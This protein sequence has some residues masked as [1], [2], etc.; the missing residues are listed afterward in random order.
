[1]SG[2][3][4]ME[5]PKLCTEL[6]FTIKLSELPSD[7][8]PASFS[9]WKSFIGSDS[10]P[11]SLVFKP[12]AFAT[13]F[14]FSDIV[15]QLDFSDK[16][17]FEV[18]FEDGSIAF[19]TIPSRDLARISRLELQ[20]TR[21]EAPAGCLELET[22]TGIT[23]ETVYLKLKGLNLKDMDTW[24]KSDPYFQVIVPFQGSESRLYCSEIVQDN[25]DPLWR[26]FFLPKAYLHRDHRDVKVRIEV[27]DDDVGSSDFIGACVTSLS[28]LLTPDTTLVLHNRTDGADSG[29]V[30]GRI[31]VEKAFAGPT[32]TLVDYMRTGVEFA[33]SVAIDFSLKNRAKSDPRSLH[34]LSSD[35]N[36]YLNALKCLSWFFRNF[37]SNGRYDLYG[38][39]AKVGG[40]DYVNHF[41][42]VASNVIGTE[43]V[44]QAYRSMLTTLEFASPCYL[45]K[46][47]QG[48]VLP[49]EH[50]PLLTSSGPL[51]YNILV[52]LTQGDLD[53]FEE[54]KE[55]LVRASN[56]PF[57]I[58]IVGVGNTA[59]PSLT[60]ADSDRSLMKSASGHVEERDFVQRVIY[61]DFRGN[62]RG[63]VHEAFAE[64]PRQLQEFM[65]A[66][67][68]A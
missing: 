50:H 14:Q 1:M 25:L 59:F 67:K 8:P 65:M 2:C 21:N 16:F 5:D 41:F 45:H 64:I 54:F 13:S 61:S 34:S 32:K 27:L 10:A 57:S 56:L 9:V 15:F 26:G 51:V 29:A 60:T 4:I 17:K 55:Q 24:S 53:D 22:S 23:S 36:S 44:E 12:N 33:M 11:E 30:T 49:Y 46:A 39:G 19:A 43:G 63:F 58:V 7:P 40:S 66:N 42:P 28:Q 62:D 52:I 35:S 68:L 38:F 18:K 37:D 31:L 47:L 6:I 48:L 20:L 3:N